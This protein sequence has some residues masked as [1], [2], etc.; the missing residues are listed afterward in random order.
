VLRLVERIEAN[1]MGLADLVTGFVDFNAVHEPI[2]AAMQPRQLGGDDKPTFG[3]ENLRPDA[4]AA[5]ARF[6]RMPK[7]YASL[8]R[9]QD[10]HGIGSEQARKIQI[11]QYLANTKTGK[12]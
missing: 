1:K 7:L 12:P 4:A 11:C 8:I 10:R 2:P 5:K 6:A 3:Y 9:T